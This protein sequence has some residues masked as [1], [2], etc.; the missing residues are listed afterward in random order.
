MTEEVTLT[1]PV[2]REEFRLDREPIRSEPRTQLPDAAG[3]GEG[4]GVLSEEE[5]DFVLY[6]ER[7]VVRM[8]TV[9]VERIKVRKVI[10]TGE[11]EIVAE[12]RK[13]RIDTDV[14]EGYDG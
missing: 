4:E 6:A 10:V 13:E 1:V 12:V 14:S 9:P 2:S 11:Q 8:E 3:S 5:Y 7:P